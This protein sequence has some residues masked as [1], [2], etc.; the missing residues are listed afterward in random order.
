MTNDDRPTGIYKQ[1]AI[2]LYK[3]AGTKNDGSTDFLSVFYS[4]RLSN[5][6][7]MDVHTYTN[8]HTYTN[9]HTYTNMHTH[10][11]KVYAQS[12]FSSG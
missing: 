3:N 4:V 7:F 12:F 6:V 8:M 1:E 9:V 5:T 11:N 10:A 2:R